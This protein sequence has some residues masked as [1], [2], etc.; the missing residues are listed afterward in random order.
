MSVQEYRELT[1]QG[2]MKII[3]LNQRYRREVS[4]DRNLQGR[5]ALTR[6]RWGELPMVKMDF[7][8]ANRAISGNLTGVL[9]PR[10]MPQLN[11]DI[12]V[13]R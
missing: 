4:L 10:P 7:D 3:E 5:N 1:S 2:R 9:A 11:A 13:R 6:V 8:I 12:M